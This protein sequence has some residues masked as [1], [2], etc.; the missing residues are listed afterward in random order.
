MHGFDLRGTSNVGTLAAM[1]WKWL[2]KIGRN[3]SHPELSDRE[4]SQRIRPF[5]SIY[6]S[7]QIYTEW[8]LYYND[9]NCCEI[10][11]KRMYAI[12]EDWKKSESWALLC[13]NVSLSM[14]NLKC[15][16]NIDNSMQ[17]VNSQCFFFKHKSV[18]VIGSNYKLNFLSW[19]ILWFRTRWIAI[20]FYYDMT[21]NRFAADLYL[22]TKAQTAADYT[23]TIRFA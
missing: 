19:M 16:F 6:V 17:Q 11:E 23:I 18:F 3:N 12:K 9:D 13:F 7:V 21:D 8:L 2:P 5:E 14:S 20:L 22:C 4:I 10:S 1:G 15:K